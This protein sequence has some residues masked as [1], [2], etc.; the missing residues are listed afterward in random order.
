MKSAGRIRA[1]Q[2]NGLKGRGPR[3]AAGKMMAR[4][5]SWR[6]GL[7]TFN[8][9]NPVHAPQ[10]ADVAKRIC[11]RDQHP[12]LTEQATIIAECEVLIGLIARE[13]GAIIQRSLVRI[14]AE[15]GLSPPSTKVDPIEQAMLE[16]QAMRAAMP[17]LLR[18]GRYE[19]RVWSKKKRAILWF[20][21]LRG[22]LRAIVPTAEGSD[23]TYDPLTGCYLVKQAMPEWEGQLIQS[24]FQ[25]PA[26]LSKPELGS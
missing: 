10:I 11:G 19:R 7:S 17:E 15:A 21:E 25:A 24:I 8:R 9:S 22:Y 14:E 16:N 20:S 1:S 4:R 18:L 6:H 3:T 13:R 5:N 23:S 26:P 12:L 2:L